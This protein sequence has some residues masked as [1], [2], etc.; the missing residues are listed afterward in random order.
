MKSL[1]RICFSLLIIFVSA[2]YLPMIYN[3]LF[4]DEVEKTHLFYSPVSRDFIYKEKVVGQVPEAVLATAEDHHAEI[5]YRKADGNYVDR[6]TFEKHLPFIFYKNMDIWGLLPM[7]LRGA[8]GREYTFT[9]SAIKKS[10]RVLELKSRDIQGNAPQTPA[11]PLFESNPGQARLVFPDDRFYMTHGGMEFIN[12]DTNA[13]DEKLTHTFT[14]A[15]RDAGFVFPAR[16]VNGK[17][18]VLKPFDQGVFLVDQAFAVFHLKR[19][20]GLPVVVKTPISPSLNTRH[21]KS[22]EDKRGRYYGLLLDGGGRLHLFSR[23]NYG[24]IPLDLPGYDPDTMDV[25]LI[26]NPLYCTV[27]YSD[28]AIIHGG[29]FDDQFKRLATYTHP[30]S[31]QTPIPATRIR[32]TLFPF[33]LE[34]SQAGFLDINVHWVPGFAVQ[35]LAAWLGIYL[36]MSIVV[37]NKRPGLGKSA[38]VGFLG[39]Y[40]L[41]AL[42]GSGVDD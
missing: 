27:V 33:S 26:F 13:L 39:P 7:A 16:S 29:V 38:L 1:A 11:W 8:D 42:L 19:V 40:G 34:P 12:A 31:R 2:L 35:G 4:L 28:D 6:V 18:T 17:F 41:V 23:E 5:A 10:R 32:D 30:M 37:F 9:K 14:Q 22:S 20:N 25:K 3:T 15:L 21:I 24:L 36:F